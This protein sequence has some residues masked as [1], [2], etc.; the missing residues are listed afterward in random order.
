MAIEK[1]KH[2]KVSE[3]ECIC[4]VCQK[5]GLS[6]VANE[7]HFLLICQGYTQLREKLIPDKFSKYPSYEKMI[8]LLQSESLSVIKNVALYIYNKLF[9]IVTNPSKHSYSVC[10]KCLFI[11]F[12][13]HYVE[14]E[15]KYQLVLL[16]VRCNLGYF[17]LIK[18]LIVW[19]KIVI[20][21]LY[22]TLG[23]SPFSTNKKKYIK[24][25]N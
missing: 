24:T 6:F 23:L 2:R 18:L 10:I 4:L 20:L 13:Y 3:Q 17:N 5:K 8:S 14:T 16:C 7:F 21:I 1:G 11:Y 12:F 22:S 9:Y 25:I 19:C 15:L